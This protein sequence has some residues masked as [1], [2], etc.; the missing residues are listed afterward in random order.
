MMGHIP[1]ENPWL[2]Q[3]NLDLRNCDLRKVL[4]RFM[5]RLEDLKIDCNDK[6][7]ISSNLKP[8]ISTLR[9]IDTLFSL[10]V[11]NI[12]SLNQSQ[13]SSPVKISE[14]CCDLL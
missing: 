4:G 2:V 11:Q 13:N 8:R 9:S 5:I 10:P 6:L 12:F 7:V 1:S 14:L 3:I